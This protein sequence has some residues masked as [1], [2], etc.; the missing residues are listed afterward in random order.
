M[1][2]SY[3]FMYEQ[4]CA[5]NS[6]YSTV[7]TE[8]VGDTLKKWK[9]KI[10]EIIKNFIKNIKELFTKFKAKIKSKGKKTNSTSG[11]S[12]TS[13]NTGN[14]TKN[15]DD[16]DNNIKN[17]NGIPKEDID[18]FMEYEFS[19]IKYK[20]LTKGYKLSNEFEYYNY[21][22]F[23]D[24]YSG[25]VFNSIANV[26]N[27]YNDPNKF[28]DDNYLNT[29]I[30]EVYKCVSLKY[31]GG[32]IDDSIIVRCINGKP[33]ESKQSIE[34]MLEHADEMYDVD[35]KC[36]TLIKKLNDIMSS[37]NNYNN[38]DNDKLIKYTNFL[39]TTLDLIYSLNSKI[40]NYV[41]K[42]RDNAYDQVIES[43]KYYYKD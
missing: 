28:I 27:K 39:K 22:I 3:K 5:F 18:R 9:D 37:I 35:D 20:E 36:G 30:D 23:K 6:L 7:F 4:E 12:T 24:L 43:L 1:E 42:I 38:I 11:S 13:T 14:A 2:E 41:V 8:G 33:I 16:K 25:E 15:T 32:T 40:L 17:V 31:K 26:I 10:I 34:K 21:E 29:A 19:D